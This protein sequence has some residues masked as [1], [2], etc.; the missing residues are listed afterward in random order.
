MSKSSS[1]FVVDGG[2]YY[3]EVR[4]AFTSLDAAK[5]YVLSE[6]LLDVLDGDEYTNSLTMIVNEYVGADI[7]NTFEV[8]CDGFDRSISKVKNRNKVLETLDLRC[9]TH[10]SPLGDR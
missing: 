7:V 10:L 5:D 9:V 4:G 2:D 6:V 3:Q 8:S 1:V